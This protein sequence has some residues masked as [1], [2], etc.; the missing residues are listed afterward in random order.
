MDDPKQILAQDLYSEDVLDTNQFD[1]I[2]ASVPDL[3]PQ[4]EKVVNERIA[5]MQGIRSQQQF[6]LEM[7]NDFGGNAH[8]LKSGVSMIGCKRLA[9]LCYKLELLGLI[10]PDQD[11]NALFALYDTQMSPILQETMQTLQQ[12]LSS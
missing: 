12:R 4:V 7:L 9:L 11:G 3:M 10:G 1:L 5:A 2:K 6:T 8:A